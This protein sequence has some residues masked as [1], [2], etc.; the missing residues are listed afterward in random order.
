MAS[1]SQG[2]AVE[3][4]ETDEGAH[5][6]DGRFAPP[7]P[8]PSFA[9]QMPPSPEGEGWAGGHMGPPLQRFRSAVVRRG[10]CPHRPA[11][12]ASRRPR[13]TWRASPAGTHMVRPRAATRGR[14]YK[15]LPPGRGKL[16]AVRLTDEGAHG[17]DGRFC[18]PP[19]IRH[20]LAAVPPSPLWGEGW[21]GAPLIAFPFRPIPP[22]RGKCPEGTKG[23][24]SGA[25]R[26]EADEALRR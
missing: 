1:P 26:S 18:P 6:D 25:E 3:R 17:D 8:H 23:V 20:R 22:V 12:G 2:E 7:P 24:G 10:R 19:L 16:S 5:G 11:S 21:R 9:S 14:P 13:P 15:R 4:S